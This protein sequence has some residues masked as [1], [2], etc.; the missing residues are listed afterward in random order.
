MIFVP[1][2]N[3]GFYLAL[4]DYL[5]E[6][7]PGKGANQVKKGKSRSAPSGGAGSALA[8]WS[9]QR[10][11]RIWILFSLFLFAAGAVSAFSLAR[12]FAAL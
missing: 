7:G 3:R 8:E 12:A 2:K 6:K 9:G 11:R 1:E 10:Q 5:G 4:R